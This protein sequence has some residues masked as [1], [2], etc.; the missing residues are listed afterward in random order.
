MTIAIPKETKVGENRVAASPEVVRKLVALGFD[1]TVEKDAGLGSSYSND[2]YQVAGAV[3]AKDAGDTLRTAEMVWKVRAPKG[4]ELKKIKR[5]AIL[6]ASLDA[7]TDNAGILALAE[8]GLTAFAMELMPRISRAQSMDILSSQGNLAGYKAIL[9]AAGE[10][11]RGIP[12]MMTAAG[13]IPP[14]KAFIMGVGVAGLQAIATAK[15]LGA[16]VTATDVRPATRE[17]VQ[18][19]GGKFLS[20]DEEMEKNA[21][22]ESGY[23]DQ[24]P[25]EYLKKQKLVVADHIKKQD[26]VITTALIPGRLAPV[27]ITKEMVASMQPGSVI[28]DLAVEAGGNVEGSKVDEIVRSSNGVKIIGHVNVPS[29]LAESASALFGRNLFN[30][31]VPMV[32]KDTGAISIDWQ[33]E[34]VSGTLVT[35]DGKVI[36]RRLLAKKTT[37]SKKT[38]VKKSTSK[39][40]AV[41]KRRYTA[42]KES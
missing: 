30:F 5:G 20:V 39:G 2:A 33:D 36:N 26:L 19:L 16:V 37:V 25:S 3:I 22:T 34:T 42:K 41:K 15:R 24:M 1:V 10:Y 17:Q 38:N 32:D 7:L 27:L 8:A 35:K 29:R 13:T 12:M 31:I 28:V 9:D 18:S 11:G 4:A 40:K 6:M 23:A 14:A 21:E